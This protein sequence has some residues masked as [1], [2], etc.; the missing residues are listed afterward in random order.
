MPSLAE[1]ERGRERLPAPPPPPAPSPP[2]PV[3]IAEGLGL[4]VES[5]LRVIVRCFLYVVLGFVVAIV[6]LVFALPAFAQETTISV[7]QGSPVFP[8]IAQVDCASADAL[9]ACT[10]HR[11]ACCRG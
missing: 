6:F 4:F 2:L 7:P 9:N 3:T 11:S 5:W 10:S 8:S 1:V